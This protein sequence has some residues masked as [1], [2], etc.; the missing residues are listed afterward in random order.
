MEKIK[1]VTHSRI[2]ALNATLAVLVL[3]L[4]L[5]AP[6]A[7]FFIA[8]SAFAVKPSAQQAYVY[9]LDDAGYVSVVKGSK[10]IKTINFS[11]GYAGA[12]GTYDP[13]NGMVYVPDSGNRYL[14]GNVTVISVAKNRIVKTIHGFTGPVGTLWVPT[15]NFVYVSDG[16]AN[17]VFVI[18]ASTN[19]VVDN[20]TVGDAPVWLAY[21]P[22]TNTVWVSNI[23]SPSISIISVKTNTVVNTLTANLTKPNGIAYDPSNKMMYVADCCY[24]YY[25]GVFVYNASDYKLVKIITNSKDFNF[26][27]D[28]AYNPL[29]KDMYVTSLDSGIHGTGSVIIL[30]GTRILK[31][32]QMPDNSNPGGVAFNPSNGLMYVA[33]GG[34]NTLSMINGTKLLNKQISLVPGYNPNGLVVS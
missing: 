6:T 31:V 24:N 16:A 5:S 7:S 14:N 13:V 30:S 26:L 3:F 23:F 32:I 33:N 22:I 18:N 28:I 20:I 34:I 15:N 2:L 17:K 9:A 21:D 19:K 25:G 29:N 8:S 10:L 12:Q 1:S 11:S 4:T 27:W